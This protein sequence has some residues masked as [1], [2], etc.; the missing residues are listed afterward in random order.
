MNSEHM[1]TQNRHLIIICE[2]LYATTAK[3]KK[4]NNLIEQNKNLLNFN[5]PIWTLFIN[6]IW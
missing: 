6:V 1:V 5:D 4:E 3:K 2:I